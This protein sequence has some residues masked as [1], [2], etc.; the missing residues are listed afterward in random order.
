MSFIFACELH[1]F[2][3]SGTDGEFVP[4][5]GMG[6]LTLLVNTQGF[7]R[8]EPWCICHFPW[9]YSKK[10]KESSVKGAGGSVHIK[11]S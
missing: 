10:G 2:T 8:K 7:G 11:R 6:G 5:I 4:S 1:L 9:R 3:C